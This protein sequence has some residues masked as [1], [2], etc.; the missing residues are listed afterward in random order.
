M[1]D[2]SHFATSCEQITRQ[3]FKSDMA[4]VRKRGELCVLAA[5]GIE[6]EARIACVPRYLPLV[7]WFLQEKKKKNTE[8]AIPD[9]LP[10]ISEAGGP[11]LTVACLGDIRI[12]A[13]WV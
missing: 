9:S 12:A 7:F 8:G 3:L 4:G 1:A 11:G 6:E 5:L 10:I 2:D 13:T